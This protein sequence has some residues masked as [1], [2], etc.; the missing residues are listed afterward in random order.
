MRL[1]RTVGANDWCDSVSQCDGQKY[2]GVGGGVDRVKSDGESSHVISVDGSDAVWSVSI[3]DG[4]IYTLVYNIRG[5]W[6]VR[7][8]DSDY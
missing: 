3:Y 8:Y 2:V 5:A 7:V 1:M 6:S 4:V